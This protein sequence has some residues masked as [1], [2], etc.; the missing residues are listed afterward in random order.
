M[1]C[2][3]NGVYLLQARRA[4]WERVPMQGIELNAWPDLVD[5]NQNVVAPFAT[6]DTFD[7]SYLQF[8]T[9]LRQSQAPVW[10]NGSINV[11][12]GDYPP[13]TTTVLNSWRFTQCTATN[14]AGQTFAGD[15]NNAHNELLLWNWIR[16]AA[17]QTPPPSPRRLPGL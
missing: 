15:L 4:D 10:F 13:N 12:D 14:S 3:T 2:L 1:A 8:E 17:N 11:I 6:N 16:L 9:I 7:L 5:Y